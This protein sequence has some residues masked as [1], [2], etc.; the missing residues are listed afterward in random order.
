MD[1]LAGGL[2]YLTNIIGE[3]A[4]SLGIMPDLSQAI[5]SIRGTMLHKKS[6]RPKRSMDLVSAMGGGSSGVSESIA[7]TLL[8]AYDL[9]VSKNQNVVT[10]YLSNLVDLLSGFCVQTDST[11][12]MSAS[13]QN[14]T[15]IQLQGLI[16]AYK[17][18]LST[19]YSLAGTN[20]KT[21]SFINR[22]DW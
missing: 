5:G 9:L 12:I 16:P 20:S 3:N 14:F 18:F 8:V 2:H 7:S 10:V 17:S 6:S 21:V 15:T 11:R 19:V 22:Q 4:C 1:R 13:G